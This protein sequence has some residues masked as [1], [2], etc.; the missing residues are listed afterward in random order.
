MARNT[1]ALLVLNNDAHG[2]SDYVGLEMA[3]KILKGSGLLDDEINSVFINNQ[4]IFEK[5][6]GGL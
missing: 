4:N 2:P 1:G 6:Y 5:A 3:T